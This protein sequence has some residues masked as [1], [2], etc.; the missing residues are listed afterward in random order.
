MV[1]VGTVIGEQVEGMYVGTGHLISMEGGT[2]SYMK[3]FLNVVQK[4]PCFG[5]SINVHVCNK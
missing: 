2:R 5:G 3:I 4:K 1:C